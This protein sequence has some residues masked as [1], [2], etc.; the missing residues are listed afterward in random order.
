MH[1]ITQHQLAVHASA[2]AC[3]QAHQLHSAL[4][5]GERHLPA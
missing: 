4:W 5:S 2:Q 1:L 3:R